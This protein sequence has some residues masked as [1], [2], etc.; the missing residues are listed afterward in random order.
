MS[1]NQFQEVLQGRT[2]RM[3][4]TRLA[5]AYA[6]CC[7]PRVIPWDMLNSAVGTTKLRF[8]EV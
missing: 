4:A 5:S 6:T 3:R 1:R 8:G 2:G 7:R